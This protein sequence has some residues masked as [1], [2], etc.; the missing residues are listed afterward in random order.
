ML[1]ICTKE[2]LS[3][4]L[5]DVNLFALVNIYSTCTVLCQGNALNLWEQ[6]FSREKQMLGESV[7]QLRFHA[8]I[9]KLHCTS[10]EKIF[11]KKNPQKLFSHPALREITQCP[12]FVASTLDTDSDKHPGDVRQM[13][14]FE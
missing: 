6:S 5:T 10:T 4:S 9:F 14:N 3:L 8:H 7:A 11:F 2:A 1:P 12:S 13:A